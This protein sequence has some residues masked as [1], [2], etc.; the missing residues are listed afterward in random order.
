MKLSGPVVLAI[1]GCATSVRAADAT[2]P[3][4][5]SDRNTP[6]APAGSVTPAKQAPV[7]NTAVQD[8]RVDKNVLEKQSSSLGER[9]AGVEVKETHDKQ[10][11]E[12]DARRPQTVTPPTSAYNHRVAAIS[13]SADT[14][15]PPI[16]TKYQDGLT[17]ASER[18]MARYPAMDGA[19]SAKI[20][21]FVFRKN[22][23][24]PSATG[25]HPVTA[26][27]GGAAVQK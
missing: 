26:A 1:I 12:K 10:V 25:G 7:A 13:T 14:T 4:D 9:R 17:A 3:I 16:V 6:F 18:T 8:K 24:E 2:T 23:A 20:N 19:T 11:R 15:K 21:R 27:G 5:Y 22:P